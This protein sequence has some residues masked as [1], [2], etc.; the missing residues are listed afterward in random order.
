MAFDEEADL[1]A[2]GFEGRGKGLV[3]KGSAGRHEAGQSSGQVSRFASDV[4][5]DHKEDG[6]CAAE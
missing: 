4:R 2:V 3:E 5:D 1:F 6:P